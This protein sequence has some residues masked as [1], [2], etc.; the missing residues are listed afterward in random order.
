MI[1]VVVMMEA[2]AVCV[3]V[4]DVILPI[5]G[6]RVMRSIRQHPKID[7]N[8]CFTPSYFH[9]YFQP[10]EFVDIVDMIPVYASLGLKQ[11]EIVTIIRL[12]RFTCRLGSD[13]K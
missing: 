10:C 12:I 4:C 7:G 9:S 11:N 5:P 1:V 13:F 2:A 6:N 8:S 3:G